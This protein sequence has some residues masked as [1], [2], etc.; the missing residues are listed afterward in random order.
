MDINGGA[1]VGLA[2]VLGGGAGLVFGFFV[3]E[4]LDVKRPGQMSLALA[5]L[6]GLTGAMVGGTFVAP[7]PASPTTPA[8]QPIASTAVTTPPTPATP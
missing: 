6:G 8:L 1:K 4:I 7:T 5:A 3:G 2:T